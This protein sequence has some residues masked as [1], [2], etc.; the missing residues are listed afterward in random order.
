SALPSGGYRTVPHLKGFAT[1]GG[2]ECQAGHMATKVCVVG[3]VNLDAVFTV[4]ALP[5]PG[6]TVLGSAPSPHP[7]GKGGN[8]AVAATRAGAAVAFVGAVGDD[9]AGTRL[10]RHLGD[11]PV[12]TDGLTTVTEPSGAAI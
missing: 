2:H 3:S 7:G 9:D 5:A 12:G 11:N 8:Q 10:R 1:S 4:A 6:E